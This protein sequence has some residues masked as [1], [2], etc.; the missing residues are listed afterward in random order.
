MSVS[1]QFITSHMSVS[2]HF[3]TSHICESSL[4]HT[5]ISELSLHHITH[6]CESSLH[7]RSF[8]LRCCLFSEVERFLNWCRDNSHD[9]N[10]KKTKE[11]LI[12]FRKA[13][14]VIPDLFIGGM[15]VERVTEYKYLGTVLDN[16]LNFNRNTY[17]IHKKCQP[18][19]SKIS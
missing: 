18:S 19:K 7:H 2:H 8:Q 10:V 11:M 12:D 5:H 17:F 16:K 15:K 6:V 9:L 3:I 14:T 4:H 1:H 13:P